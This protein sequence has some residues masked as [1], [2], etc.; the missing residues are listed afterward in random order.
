VSLHTDILEKLDNSPQILN[1]RFRSGLSMY[2]CIRYELMFLIL[3]GQRGGEEA[4]QKRKPVISKKDLLSYAFFTWKNRPRT[5]RVD[6]LALANCEND[7]ETPNKVLNFVKEIKD[8]KTEF[9]FYSPRLIRFGVFSGFYSWDYFFYYSLLVNK[10][11]RRKKSAKKQTEISNFIALLRSTLPEKTEEEVFRQMEKNLIMMEQISGTY[12]KKLFSFLKKKKPGMVLVS[13]GN[14]G[15]W[16]HAA[17]FMVC[18]ELGIKTA[19]MQHGT[20]GAGMRYAEVL[21]GQDYFAQHKSDVVFTFG[22]YH[23]TQTNAVPLKIP[24]GHYNPDYQKASEK[25]VQPVTGKL[26]ILLLC[27]GVNYRAAN[28]RI[29]EIVYEALSEADFEYV[30]TVRLHPSDDGTE[31]FKKLLTLK[32]VHLSTQHTD[33]MLTLLQ[34]CDVVMGYMSTALFEA[35]LLNKPVVYFRD[36]VSE[37]HIPADIGE[38]YNSKESLSGILEKIN[39]NNAKVNNRKD[40]FWQ[41]GQVTHNIEEYIIK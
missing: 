32:N 30:L 25:P 12:K 28:N 39:T 33:D 23:N 36:E 14:N 41:T 11:M 9:G 22:P 3:H 4:L 37:K 26:R 10:L 6:M 13:E 1:Y 27:E 8:L 31:R 18:K 17:L 7:S 35:V 19:E 34:D 5:H 24:V 38:A 40:W 29:T 16:Q 21:A 20:F 2:L 15:G